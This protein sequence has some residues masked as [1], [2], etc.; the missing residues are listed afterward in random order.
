ML[1]VT[2]LFT[3]CI[4]H[5]SPTVLDEQVIKHNVPAGEDI[6]LHCLVTNGGS[7]AWLGPGGIMLFWKERRL[8]PD[9]RFELQRP[10]SDY[11]N[12]FIRNTKVADAGSYICNATQSSQTVS[13]VF[14][15]TVS[16]KAQIQPSLSSGDKRIEE[17]GNVS[18]TCIAKGY[19]EP[20]ITWYKVEDNQEETFVGSGQQLSITDIRREDAGVYKCMAFNGVGM[21]DTR[22]IEIDVEYFPVILSRKIIK[23]NKMDVK[24]ECT[25]EWNPVEE[26][27][28]LKDGELIQKNWKYNPQ[29][30]QYNDSISMIGLTIYQVEGP[31]DYGMYSCIVENKH[32]KASLTV[33]LDKS[34]VPSVT[35]PGK[36]DNGSEQNSICKSMIIFATIIL[37]YINS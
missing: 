29:L 8:T 1:V 25:V 37:F 7:V 21:N 3:L 19:P 13:R 22:E 17:G 9:V 10:Y 16:K 11:W 30:V 18:L 34:N 35:A 4:I 33:R 14:E 20:Q 32:G 12:L 26:Y 23:I 27:S 15:L 36:G 31:S 24:I 2:F 28:W 5:V 6:L